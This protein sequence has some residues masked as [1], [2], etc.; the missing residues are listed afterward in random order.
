MEVLA[1]YGNEEQ[2]KQWREPLR[3]DFS[4]SRY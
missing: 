4:L 1:R 3:E 2:K